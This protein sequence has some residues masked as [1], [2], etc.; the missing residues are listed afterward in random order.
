MFFLPLAAGLDDVEL[1][2]ALDGVADGTCALP[3][4]AAPA[5]DLAG[6]VGINAG[7]ENARSVL[8]LLI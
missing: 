1:L 4:L 8:I 5:A 7:S 6:V 3:P 2:L